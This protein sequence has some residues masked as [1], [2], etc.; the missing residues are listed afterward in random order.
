M[1][2]ISAPYSDCE[3]YG[4]CPVFDP[5]FFMPTNT[6]VFGNFSFNGGWENSGVSII[7]GDI[8][9]QTGYFYNITSLNITI[10]NLTIIDN[11]IVE[12]NLTADY[13]F[14]NWNGSSDYVLRAGDTMTGTLFLDAIGTG[15]D[16]LYSAEI[17]NHLIVGDDLTVGGNL[18]VEE[19]SFFNGDD[20]F[21]DATLTVF[22]MPNPGIR[23]QR[24]D[25]TIQTG[26]TLGVISFRGGD[27][28]LGSGKTG[29]YIQTTADGTWNGGS[30]NP[31]IFEIFVENEGITNGLGTPVLKHNQNFHS[32]FQRNNLL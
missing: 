29:A 5:D 2:I 7:D 9:A 28:D 25:A 8:Y 11:L 21:V 23:F 6:S 3:I 1:P 26:N 31:S 20:V 4:T 27:R 30:D 14:G 13:F 12:G 19:T 10:Q 17:G 32:N 22:N 15:L 16:V 24:D 18:T